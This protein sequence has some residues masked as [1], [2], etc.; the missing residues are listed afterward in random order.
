MCLTED[1]KVR[2]MLIRGGDVINA[3]W[4][5]R[6]QRNRNPASGVIK[7]ASAG[8]VDPV[9]D[10]CFVY[11]ESWIFMTRW[12]NCQR[13]GRNDGRNDRCQPRNRS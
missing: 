8:R 2:N 9:E 3:E 13:E 5:K 10:R 11:L 1:E 4:P 6:I 12:I 7:S